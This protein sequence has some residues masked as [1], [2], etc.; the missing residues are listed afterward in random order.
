MIRTWLTIAE[1]RFL[2][3]TDL[4]LPNRLGF[5]SFKYLPLPLE[6]SMSVRDDLFSLEFD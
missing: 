5:S 2:D 4:V 3:F 1:P 6:A